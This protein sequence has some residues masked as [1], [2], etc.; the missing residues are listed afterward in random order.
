MPD[1]TGTYEKRFMRSI[2]AQERAVF[3]MF[4]EFSRAVSP[5][6]SKYTAPN[7]LVTDVWYR[8]KD[9][10]AALQSELRKLQKGLTDYINDQTGK[11]WGLSAEKTDKIV[12]E[13]ISGLGLSDIA[14]E[15][16]FSRNL[17]A[18]KEFQQRKVAGMNLS[19]RVWKI[20]GETKEQLELYL[21]SGL[22]S[23]QSAAKISLDVRQYLK[24][25]DARFRR[26][27]DPETGELKPSKPMANYHPGQ[28]IYRSAYKN[29]LRMARTET[30]M[31][32]RLSDVNR[33]RNIEFIT[34]YEVKLSAAHPQLDICFTNWNYKVLTSKGW[35]TINKVKEGDLVLTHK[36]KFQRVTKKYKTTVYEVDKTEV[37]YKTMYDNRGKVHTISATD[38]HPFLVNGKWLQ[39]SKIKVG[40][41]IN[42]LANKCGKCGKLIPY[43]RNFCS[44]SCASINTTEKQWADPLHK[45]K[46]SKKRILLIEKNGG[47]L[48]WL[49]D[50]IKSGKNTETLLR[51]DVKE[52]AVK[53]QRISAAKLVANGEHHF[54][55]PELRKKSY[56]ALGKYHNST[57]IE[58]KMEW[59]LIEKDIE[60]KKGVALK[61]KVLNK[62]GRPRVYLPD[63]ILPKYDIVIECDGEYWHKDIVKDLKRQGEIEQMGFRV[64]RF[65]DKQIRNNLK[66]CSQEIDRVLKNHNGE[67]SFVDIEVIKVNKYKQKQKTPITKYNLE[68]ENDNS[69]IVNG[70]VVHNCD[71]MVGEYPKTFTFS[72][73]HSN[74]YDNETEVFTAKGWMKFSDVKIG[75]VVHSINQKTKR[76]EPANCIAKQEYDYTGKMVHYSNR[77]LDLMVTPEHKMVYLSKVTGEILTNKIADNYDSYKGGLYRYCEWEGENYSHV[78]IGKHRIDIKLF[79]EFMGYW[80]SD[81]SYSRRFAF[82]IAQKRGHDVENRKRIFILLSKMPFEIHSR[83]SGFEMY[84]KDFYEYLIQFG[85]SNEKFIPEIIKESTKDVVKVFLDAFISCDGHIGKPRNFI[86]NRGTEFISKS[87]ERVYFTSSER[88]AGDIGELI[89]KTGKRPSFYKNDSR[90]K[91][92]FP[93]GVYNINYIVHRISECSSQTATVFNKDYIDYSGKVY[94]LSLDKNHT[95]YVRRKGKCVWSSNCFCYV[96]P[97]T[98]TKEEFV[99]YIKNDKLPGKTVKGIPPKAFNYIKEKSASL[100]KMKNKPYWLDNF[101]EKG[102]VYYPKASINNPKK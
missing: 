8:N 79:A 78:A 6:L 70:V 57:F 85:K 102:G 91:H 25:P 24:N 101:K 88:M 5:L 53:A 89:L 40:D 7:L 39:I 31:A 72:G 52:K 81:G 30:N 29:A 100:A 21:Q 14:K 11:A 60:Y 41:K 1:I 34:G 77:S 93:N 45:E 32:Y 64:L 63:F 3:N 55:D 67:Y 80:L 50:Y 12:N 99:D 42:M 15:G 95:L 69:Y 44:K 71:Y 58:K 74:C 26:V 20:A 96:V 82:S 2:T 33:W 46:L 87:G 76:L 56:Q 4:S 9:I 43:N 18:L 36:G 90:G 51:A 16:L 47:K 48:P 35:V 54:Q 73:W 13:Y 38:N 19:E 66:S 62:H 23:G 86:G 75:D 17:E 10:E 61:R 98:P 59:L 27:R 22:S 28:G 84:D 68:V 37:S 94:D 92:Q 65:T 97:I 83:E 49:A